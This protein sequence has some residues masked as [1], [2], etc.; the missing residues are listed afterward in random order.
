MS[1]IKYQAQLN[2]ACFITL[3]PGL[4]TDLCNHKEKKQYQPWS[5]CS[6]RNPLILVCSLK[7]QEKLHFHLSKWSKLNPFVV[8]LFSIII[9]AAMSEN[10]SSGFPTRPDTNRTV[11]QP[12]KMTRDLKF[13]IWKAE[14]LYH[15][16]GE[17]KGTDQLRGYRAA[18]LRL[19]ICICKNPVF[20]RHG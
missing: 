15:P 2:W 6:E 5:D 17:S 10:R 14:G 11:L 3:G 16:S 18:D 13:R 7:T 12:Q 19:C 4:I 9:W 20:S 1:R 8:N